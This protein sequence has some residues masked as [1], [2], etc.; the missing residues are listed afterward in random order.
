MAAVTSTIIAAIGL[1]LSAVG[2]AVTYMGQQKA[3]AAQKKQEKIRKQQMNLDLMRQR[4]EALRKML[5]ARALGIS[6]AANQ[7]AGIAD[8]SVQGGIA[9]ATGQGNMSLTDINQN[10]QLGTAMFKAN[11]MEASGQGTAAMGSVIGGFGSGL[12]NNSTTI[13]RVGAG[14][15]FWKNPY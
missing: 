10:G 15:G 1:G 2:G 12:V 14:F 4:R 8:S 5:I 3:A 6:N 13:S 7:G 11:A 9:Q